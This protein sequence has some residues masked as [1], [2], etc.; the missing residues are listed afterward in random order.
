LGD[1][2]RGV[3]R[4]RIPRQHAR[5]GGPR[6]LSARRHV[7]VCARVVSR[8]RRRRATA[9]S[10]VAPY[11]CATQSFAANEG[12]LACPS[13]SVCVRACVCIIMSLRAV[14][15]CAARRRGA[16]AACVSSGLVRVCPEEPSG[17]VR[18]CVHPPLPCLRVTCMTGRRRRPALRAVRHLH[19]LARGQ[20]LGC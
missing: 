7:C 9:L 12:R 14:A 4:V 8:L 20:V 16:R 19:H 15:V 17:L 5:R 11:Y 3:P 10:S 6:V 13:L 18:V 1:A 2:A